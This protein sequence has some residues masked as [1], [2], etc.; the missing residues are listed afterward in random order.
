M[1]LASLVTSRRRF[2]RAAVV[3]LAATLVVV[4]VASPASAD[5]SFINAKRSAAGLA[6]V[7]S[8]GGLA[9]LAQRHSQ[10]MANAGRLFHTGDLGG[11]VSSVLPGW[12]SVG[13]NVGVGDSVDAVNAMFMQ[14]PAHRANTLGAYNLAGVGVVQG[15]DGRYWVTQTFARVASSAPAT[16]KVT[17]APRTS[18]PRTTAPAPRPSAPRVS[19]SAPRTTVPA[20]TPPPPAPPA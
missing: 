7:S 8:S 3:F 18:A 12:Q 13:E 5:V 20:P 9:S 11:S 16:P 1:L 2:H 6:P 17:A 10:E 15:G 19:R 4:G 14:P